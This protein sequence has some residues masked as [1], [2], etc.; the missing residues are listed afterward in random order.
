MGVATRRFAIASAALTLAGLLANTSALR[1]SALAADSPSPS[2]T[3][4]ILSLGGDVTEILY[5][6]GQSDKIVAVDTTSLFPASALKDKKSV[7]Y[8]RTLSAE[9]VLS[10]NPTLIIA[11]EQAGPPEVV[12][13][14]KGGGVQYVDIE[15]KQTAEGVPDK[16]R[17]IGRIIGAEAD[18]QKLAAKIEADFAALDNDRKQIKERKKALFILAVQNGRAT[19]GGTGTGADAILQLAGIDN[20]AAGVSGYKPVSDEQLA[21]LAP[22]AVIV[23]TRGDGDRHTGNLA[24]S[25]PGLSQS[26]AAKNKRLVEMDGQYLLGFG[27]RAPSAAHDLMNALYSEPGK[28]AATP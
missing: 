25:L 27:P 16:V 12:K 5:A 11:S 1:S 17:R 13:A 10:V 7:G 14:I 9:G 21:E 8:L 22:D 15:E 20:A 3:V 4:R 24:L 2:G 26:P 18:A 23:M 28:T 6:L 19:I